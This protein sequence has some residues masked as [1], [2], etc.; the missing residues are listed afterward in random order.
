MK[1]RL[2]QPDP[3]L[4]AAAREGDPAS[5]EAIYRALS[6]MVFTLARRMLASRALAEDV[7]HETFIDAFAKL[8]T[9][10]EPAGLSAWVRRIA[11][12]H[13]LMQ[14][15]SGWMVRRTEVE[16]E[17]LA[18]MQSRRCMAAEQIALQEALDRLSPTARAVVWLH[19]VEG[20]T[21]KEIAEMMGRTASFSKSRLA[22]AHVRLQ[23][24]LEG[25]PAEGES[26]IC[27]SALKTC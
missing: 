11:V 24:L 13:C 14:L 12:N 1:R 20:Y 18:E 3:A 16:A 9:L 26:E 19:D 8:D 7:L 22:R 10:R 4:V 17:Q 2:H 6:P 27:V 21:H 15:R 5:Q 23:E 25:V